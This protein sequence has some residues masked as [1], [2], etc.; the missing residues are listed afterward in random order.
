MV[1]EL[2]Q[3]LR[4]HTDDPRFGQIIGEAIDF[5]LSSTIERQHPPTEPGQSSK[6]VA[7]I[8]AFRKRSGYYV[9]ATVIGLD[10]TIDALSSV[11]TLVRL[12]V[13]ETN[14]GS[15]AV[16]LNEHDAP[17]GVMI[18]MSKSPSTSPRDVRAR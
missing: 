13:I 16:W 17:M 12:G 8:H 2:I 14:Q 11:D 9:N 6:S 7:D 18:L 4:N 1:I 10:A 3:V 5:V 15:V